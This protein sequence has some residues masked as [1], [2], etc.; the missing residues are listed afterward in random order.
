MK[1]TRR[2]QAKPKQFDKYLCDS[3]NKTRLVDFLVN[4]WSHINRYATE[5]TNREVYIT[6]GSFCTK[7]RRINGSV[8]PEHSQNCRQIKKRQTPKCFRLQHAFN[9]GFSTACVVS[10][11]TDVAI[12]G[13]YFATMLPRTIYLQISSKLR[14]NVLNLTDCRIE[15]SL[16]KAL[17]GVH[18][19]TGCDS[20]NSFHGKGKVSA[21]MIMKKNDKFQEAS[22]CFFSINVCN[23]ELNFRTLIASSICSL[24]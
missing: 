15:D 23:A 11:D 8:L 2:D 5:L 7:L 3:G 14:T 10:V 24:F 4:D 9:E 22:D 16:K 20:T 6:H 12:L 17:P 13:I 1:I 18:A 21:L 19:I